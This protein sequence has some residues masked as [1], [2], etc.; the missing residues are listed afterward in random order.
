MNPFKTMHEK[1][2]AYPTRRLGKG[3]CYDKVRE[4]HCATGAIAHQ[5]GLDVNRLRTL[6]GEGIFTNEWVRMWAE[7]LGLTSWD[8]RMVQ[9]IN[10]NVF[11]A[12]DPGARYAHMLAT[13]KALG[14]LDEEGLK[15]VRTAYV[16]N[17]DGTA[18][19]HAEALARIMEKIR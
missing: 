1:L 4:C 11:Q 18:K 15:G 10:D 7:G 16:T 3:R 8:V 14:D 12:D 17:F 2:L 6:V 5:D 9:G 13:L 19:G